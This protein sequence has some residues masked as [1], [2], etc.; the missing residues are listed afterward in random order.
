M[1]KLI[2]FIFACV[3]CFFIIG[4]KNTYGAEIYSQSNDWIHESFL[5]ENRVNGVSYLNKDYNESIDS[6]DD[7]YIYDDT[8]PDTRT[9]VIDNEQEYNRIFKPGYLDVDFNSE[10]IYLYIFANTSPFEAYYI[11][12]ISV[13]NERVTIYIKLEYR[14]IKDSTMPYQRCVIEKMLKTETTKV[15]F[16]NER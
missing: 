10:I 14:N 8:S 4:C 2:L 6:I 3:L 15:L 7:K 13:D 9:I 11:D 12:K 16:I 1:K 5:D